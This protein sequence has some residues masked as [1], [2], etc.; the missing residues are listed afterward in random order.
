MPC[1]AAI[2]EKSVSVLPSETIENALLLI[3]KHKVNAVAVIDEKGVFQGIFS[4]KV[5]LNSLIPVSVAMNEGVQIDVKLT[6]AP[7]VAKRLSNVKPLPVSEL[8]VRKPLSVTPDAPIWKGVGLLTKNGSPL[9]VIDDKGK[10]HGLITY[11]SL[12][13]N[14]EDIGQSDG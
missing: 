4:M 1:H 6:A 12:V 8:M 2:V 11:E 7:G 9:C 5:L 10:F 13:N 14:L 3:R